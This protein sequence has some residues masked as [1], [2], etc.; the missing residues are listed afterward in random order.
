MFHMRVQGSATCTFRFGG[1]PLTST[2]QVILDGVL[3]ASQ[4][5]GIFTNV[6][7]GSL[8]GAVLIES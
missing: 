7:A 5:D 1:P 4:G 8:S 6:T 2:V 3:V